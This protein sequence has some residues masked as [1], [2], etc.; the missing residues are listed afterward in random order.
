MPYVFNTVKIWTVC[1]VGDNVEV[2]IAA[3]FL[4]FGG[5]M[6]TRVIPEDGDWPLGIFVHGFAL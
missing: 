4:D 3:E 5:D 1:G 2:H 6:D